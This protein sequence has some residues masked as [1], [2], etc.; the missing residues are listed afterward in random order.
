MQ[1][2]DRKKI[3]VMLLACI[4][5]LAIIGALVL[6]AHSD[7]SEEQGFSEL[8]FEDGDTI[9]WVNYVGHDLK[10]AFSVLSNEKKKTDYYY[11]ISYDGM[12][13]KSGAFSIEPQNSN[14]KVVNARVIFNNS[15][16]TKVGEAIVNQSE[17]RYNGLLGTIINKGSEFGHV[18]I[19]TSPKGYFILFWG[20]NT[21][22]QIDVNLPDKIIVPVRVEIGDISE[23]PGM[24]IFNP[25]QREF[26]N[27]SSSNIRQIG[28]INQLESPPNARVL[29][30]YGY[31]LHR[32]DWNVTNDY[33]NLLMQHNEELT[34]YRYGYKEILVR[35]FSNNSKIKGYDYTKVQYPGLY[36]D[37]EIH[38]W[39]IVEEDHEKQLNI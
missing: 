29:S 13:I 4:I 1:G 12:L 18:N 7:S 8:K 23:N 34:D 19:L 6:K 14:K 10:F 39:I 16:L 27:S 5:G 24:L 26:F 2:I 32:E 35:I 11:N 15:S 30:K 25:K 21:S 31:I 20:N 38:F 28:T 22:R 17:L 36:N 37:N 9:P 33:G 3:F